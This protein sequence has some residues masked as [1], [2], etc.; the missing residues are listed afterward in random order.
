L[1][2]GVAA[3]IAVANRHKIVPGGPWQS[4]PE[5]PRLGERP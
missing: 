2:P 5:D 4:G 3:Y 1:E